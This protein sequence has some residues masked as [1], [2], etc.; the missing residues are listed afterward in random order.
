MAKEILLYFPVLGVTAEEVVAQFSSSPNEDVTVRVNSPGGSVNAGWSIAS[1]MKEHEGNV[2]AVVDGFALSMAAA[3]LPFADNVIAYNVNQIM[4]HKAVANTEDEG[5]AKMLNQVNENLRDALK[6]KIDPEKFEEIA[7]DTIDNIFSPEAVRKDIWMSADEAKSMGLVDEVVE[8]TEGVEAWSKIAAM[9][10][11]NSQTKPTHQPAHQTPQ[12]KA[13]T[14]QSR[15][16]EPASNSNLDNPKSNHMTTEKLK[17][18]HPEVY[19]AIY[20]EGQKAEKDRV[21]AWMEWQQIDAEAVKK[22]I[23]DGNNLTQ[24]DISA[25]SHKA[26]TVAKKEGLE[27]EGASASATETDP[28]A[29]PP[30]AKSEEEKALEDVKANIKEL[31]K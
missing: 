9:G 30:Q 10:S 22:G 3:L 18:E 21:E 11:A 29:D 2:T 12:P 15:K 6:A 19:N 5:M 23:E 20:A 24:K 8:L 4:I 1:K 7:G 13:N 25:L 26:L 17:A 16:E 31:N 28:P 14:E 27:G